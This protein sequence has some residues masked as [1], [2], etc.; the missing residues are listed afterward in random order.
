MTNISVW[1][2]LSRCLARSGAQSVWL[3]MNGRAG[4]ELNVEGPYLGL[5]GVCVGYGFGSRTCA[6]PIG[7]PQLSGWC[8]SVDCRSCWGLFPERH[9]HSYILEKVSHR[10]AQKETGLGNWGGGRGR[11]MSLRWVG[12]VPS[13]RGARD[14]MTQSLGVLVQIQPEEGGLSEPK[15]FPVL[16]VSPNLRGEPYR[17]GVGCLWI[18]SIF[19]TSLLLK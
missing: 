1:D 19:E 8:S 4:L 6:A 17:M 12:A 15:I 7:E 18:F 9:G 11:K 10:S 3:N 2:A 16:E 5:G 13:V 14:P